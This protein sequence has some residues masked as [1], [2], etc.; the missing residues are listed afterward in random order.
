MLWICSRITASKFANTFS[1]ALKKCSSLGSY[2]LL[3]DDPI[4]AKDDAGDAE[5]DYNNVSSFW[6]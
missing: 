4:N 1:T 3:S 2:K 5:L 6:F